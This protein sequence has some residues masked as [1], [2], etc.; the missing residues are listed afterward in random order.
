VPE[1]D[2]VSDGLEDAGLQLAVEALRREEEQLQ[3][4]ERGAETQQ[5]RHQEEQQEQHQEQDRR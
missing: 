1:A 5:H 3:Q 4:K 2:P